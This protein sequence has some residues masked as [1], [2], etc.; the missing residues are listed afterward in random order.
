MWPFYVANKIELPPV[1]AFYGLEGNIPAIFRH[2]RDHRRAAVYVDLGYWGRREGGRFTGYHKVVVNARHPTAYFQRHRTDFC[3]DRF[4]RFEV[5]IL[6]LRQSPGL[7]LLAGMGDKGAIAEGFEPEQWERQVLTAI[8][9]VTDRPV[10]YRPK[11]SWKE[12]RPMPGTLYS[13]RHQDIPWPQVSAVVTHHSNVAVEALL[14]G[15][16]TWCWGGVAAPHA[17]QFLEELARPLT[18]QEFPP[19]YVLRAWAQD[20]AY[21]QWS[22]AEIAAGRCWAHLLR[23][24]LV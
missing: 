8:R 23:E 10:M 9:A 5:P 16:P 21:T 15:I 18:F 22:V 7:I 13:Q 11:P 20:I 1:A 12:A 17:R 14:N 4:G 6:P 3:I 24:E 2:Y 19:N